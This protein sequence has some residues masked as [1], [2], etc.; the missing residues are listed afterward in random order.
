MVSP[1]CM[2]ISPRMMMMFTLSR[3]IW[4]WPSAKT[5]MAPPVW[6][7][8][9]SSLGPQLLVDQGQVVGPFSGVLLL[10]TTLVPLL[11]VFCMNRAWAIFWVVVSFVGLSGLFMAQLNGLLPMPQGE[12]WQHL[13]ENFLGVV[14][15]Q[16]TQV[17]LVFVYDSANARSLHTLNRINQRL[18][19]TSDALK[20]AD[21]HKDKFL[22][23]VSHDMRT[24]LNAV[25]GYLGLL[26]DNRQLNT[27]THGFVVNAQNAAAHL[28]TVINDLLDFS[29]IRLG[30]L[31][32]HPHSVKIGR[33][34]V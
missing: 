16:I 5:A 9:G 10:L 19:R 20:M 2:E 24:P 8:K 14:V 26:R 12:S 23:M 17:I 7:L 22:A 6:K 21:S 29:Q 34:H 18:A 3:I 31:T 15:L 11:A 4:V 28:L 33:A 1:P 13:S 25:I 32:L 30:Q 27:E